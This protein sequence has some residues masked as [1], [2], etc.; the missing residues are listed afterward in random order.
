M[1][2]KSSSKLAD[3]LWTIGLTA[4][5]T[6]LAA[7]IVNNLVSS[8]KKVKHHMPHRYAVEDEQ[9]E[10]SIGQLLGPPLVGGNRVERLTNGDEIFPAMLEAIESAEVSIT[11]ESFV[12]WRGEMTRRFAQ[13]LAA[14]AREGV[15]VHVLLDGVGCD[16]VKGADV[17]AMEAVGVEVRI[18]HMSNF[19]LFNYRTHRKLL[20]VDGVV[21]F[22]G[23]VGVGDFWMGNADAE[24]HWRD[25]HYRVEG[26]VVA[27]L[28]AAFN[29]NW[30]TTQG[31]V[32]DG[33]K[34]FPRLQ[35]QGEQPCQ[36][37]KSSPQGGSE[38]ARLMF[39][40]SIAAA[41][42]RI[43]IG[44]AYFVPDDLTTQTLL[45]ACDRGVE[46][47]VL[48]PGPFQDSRLVRRASRARWGKLLKR[49]VRIFEYQPTMYHVKCMIIDDCL[50]SVGSANFDNRSFRLNDEAN[51]NILDRDFALQEGEIF[52]EDLG[53]AR[54]VT[55][56][57]W[58]RRP[59]LEKLSDHGAALFRSQL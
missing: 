8:E 18:Y 25:S 6:G 37:F 38:S 39:L 57:D 53:R 46:V 20:V 48:L 41:Q 44:N 17:R 50:T 24:D 56:E 1:K 40:L 42:R 36:L 2:K 4:A 32:L 35:E 23:G 5:G 15:A 54:E 43:R 22:T 16:C 14:K 12:F 7:V 19:A 45:D 10:R 28:Q 47:D 34:Y 29:D 31:E 11:F 55:Y 51:L 49:G 21:G 52:D 59:L 13:A 9:F 30:M 33:E 27:Q 26:P 3:Q 58:R